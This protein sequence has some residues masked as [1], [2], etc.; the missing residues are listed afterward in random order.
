[1]IMKKICL[2]TLFFLPLTSCNKGPNGFPNP[3][4]D[5]KYLSEKI[6]FNIGEHE[7]FTRALTNDEINTINDTI[8]SCDL[9]DSFINKETI[10]SHKRDYTRAF[11]GEF[12][13]GYNASNVL[14]DKEIT[15]TKYEK[16]NKPETESRRRKITIDTSK[17]IRD[18]SYGQIQ[19]NVVTTTYLHEEGTSDKKEEK[20]GKIY[21]RVKVV[22]QNKYTTVMQKKEPTYIYDEDEQEVDPSHGDKFYYISQKDFIFK[23]DIHSGAVRE[24][25][26][27]KA[28]LVVEKSVPYSGGAKPGFIKFGDERE[29]AAMENSIN[30]AKLQLIKKS[31][32]PKYDSDWYL[33]EYFRKYSEIAITSE[34]IQPN[35]PIS[36]LANPIVINFSEEICSFSISPVGY[37]SD[38]LPTITE[39]GP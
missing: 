3:F 30:V 22:Q 34:V 11:A 10:N 14:D 16:E 27:D 21:E 37:S 9:Y 33:V 2:L 20:L 19:K 17:S 18:Y 23:S 12:K 38:N 13:Q 7:K 8:A 36:M 5:D 26:K 39:V 32:N 15:I 24:D 1:M 31:D 25:N 6:G 29:Y 28:V 35:V 4:P